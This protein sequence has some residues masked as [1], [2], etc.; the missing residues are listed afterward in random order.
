MQ[1][2]APLPRPDKTTHVVYLHQYHRPPTETEPAEWRNLYVGLCMLDQL[3]Q[4]PDALAN[5][6]WHEL[7]ER[8]PEIVAH[9]LY[10]S[11]NKTDAE[12]YR[13][14]LSADMKAP[15]NQFA[16]PVAGQGRGK[17]VRCNE[18]GEIFTNAAAAC[19]AHACAPTQMS[20]HLNGVTGF[21]TVKGHTFTRII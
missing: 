15:A 21:A 8:Y 5:G 3:M 1:F 11:D 2:S 7:R 20:N 17:R 19:R 18:T 12:Q 16:R 4:P 13:D 14:Q 9:V 6:M 10:A